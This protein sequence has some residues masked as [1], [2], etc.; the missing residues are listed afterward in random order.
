MH[1]YPTN[2]LILRSH[3]VLQ[4]P[5]LFTTFKTYMDL[6][7]IA[8]KLTSLLSLQEVDHLLDNI[9]QT[10]GTLPEEI[11][12]LE[13]KELQAQRHVQES[14]AKK[15]AIEEEIADSRS[16]IKNIERLVKRYEEEQMHVRNN[17]EY[18]TI[19]KEID[20]QK[21]EVQLKEKFIKEA[22]GRIEQQKAQTEQSKEAVTECQKF[23]KHKKAEL[24]QLVDKS[25]EEERKLSE[26]REGIATSIDAHLLS[27]YEH[28]R[29][30][31]R[32]RLAVVTI[33]REACGGCF[34]RIPPQRQI[35]IH[36]KKEISTCEYCG[37]IIAGVVDDE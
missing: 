27:R 23:L 3:V 9:T 26:Q 33:K 8:Q 12:S 4:L 19:T 5:T 24:K 29:K 7:D 1:D 14:E 15:E 34:S 18:D 21:L 10:R 13:R 6:Q 32:N 22:Y 17:R 31:V 2:S 11:S 25:Q 20:L 37:R 28:I 16:E 35:S 36:E 30:S